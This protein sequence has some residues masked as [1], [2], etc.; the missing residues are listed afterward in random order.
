MITLWKKPILITGIVFTLCPVVVFA[1]ARS[2]YQWKNP[3]L[4]GIRI[5]GGDFSTYSSGANKLKGAGAP[6]GILR[7]SLVSNFNI[8]RSAAVGGAGTLDTGMPKLSGLRGQSYGSTK[9]SLPVTLDSL[10]RPK[11]DIDI[12]SAGGAVKTDKIQSGLESQTGR[13]TP[14]TTTSTTKPEKPKPISSFVPTEPS[15]YQEYMK[16]GEQAFRA[17][18]YIEAADAFDVAVAMGR[19][20]PESHLSLVHAY[21]ALGRY[22]S[23]AYQLRQALKHFPELPLVSLRVRLFY[24]RAEAFVSQMD[25][26]RQEAEKPYAGADLYLLL[27]YFRYFDGEE[28]DAAKVLRRAWNGGKGDRSTV[29]AIETFWNGM[30]AAGKVEDALAPAVKPAGPSGRR[31]VLLPVISRQP[32]TAV[33]DERNTGKQVIEKKNA[34]K[35]EQHKK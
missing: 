3:G 1:Q 22:H 25:K 11:G 33:A 21:S 13:T 8:Q 30:V 31:P 6:T 5:I 15:R 20:L 4:R 10:P 18:R 29:E 34:Q 23:A 19:Y 9:I 27:A 28:D 24:G 26:L 16:R 35:K 7:S 12:I 17:E 2:Q 14:T 32:D